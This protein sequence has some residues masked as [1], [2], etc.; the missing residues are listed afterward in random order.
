MI[1][2]GRKKEKKEIERCIKSDKSELL[3]VYG[4]RRVGKTFLVEQTIGSY[5]AFRATGLEKGNTRAQLRAFKERLIAY[6]DT[7]N[8]IPQ[9]WFE[10]FS[11]LEKILS[12][13]NA[14][15][16]EYGKKIVF[17]DEFPWFA[18]PKSDFLLAFEEYW[19]R[20]GTQYGN[21]LFIICGSAT[22]WIMKNVIDNTGNLY[23]RVTSQLFI[24]PFTL[25]ETEAYLN[26][27]EFGWS[28]EQI[29]ECQMVFGG[30]PYFLSM[31]NSNESFRQNVDRLIFAPRA[32]LRDETSRLLESTLKKNPIYGKI[33]KELST[34]TYGMKRIDCKDVIDAA[35][36]TFN[37]AI[38][39][40]EKC[41]Y[42]TASERWQEKG[43]PLYLQLIDPFLLFH[44]HFLDGNK[45]LENYEKLISNTGAYVNWRG[46]AFEILCLLHIDQIKKALGISGI[47]TTTY[48]WLYSENKNLTQIDLVIERADR[49]TDICEIKYT[50]TPYV[51]SQ[52][53]DT[54]LLKK[55]DL[56][57]EITE[58]KNAVK[59]ILISA[60]GTSGTA[61]MEH[62]SEVLTINDLFEPI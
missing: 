32:L 13:D 51:M 38:E 20:C 15:T 25:A 12:N 48:P 53:S 16:S 1:I 27:K 10:A 44:Y 56:F 58:T 18:T 62:I 7:N 19:N 35:N 4:R 37:R 31:L 57:K 6:G 24:E 34:H 14:V 41:G 50:D 52:D 40:L 39:D 22:S 26:T 28:R 43:K 61:Y 45:P 2:I 9:N 55:R 54:S 33:L 23:H 8:T 30:L 5:F 46:H 21:I 42:I 36:G 59:I 17:F 60:H 11:R 49:I 47:E 29:A 3:C